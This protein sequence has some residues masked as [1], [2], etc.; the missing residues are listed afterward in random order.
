MSLKG[1]SGGS[2]LHPSSSTFNVFVLLAIILPPDR[3]RQLTL[4]MTTIDASLL[5]FRHPNGTS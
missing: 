4:L 3:W 5:L 2:V 1:Y